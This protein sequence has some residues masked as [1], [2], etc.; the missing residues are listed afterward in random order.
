VFR[1]LGIIG[2]LTAVATTG[3]VLEKRILEVRRLR[4]RQHFRSEVLRDRRAELQL[5]TQ[6]FSGAKELAAP[7]HSGLMQP[8]NDAGQP[9][10]PL[11]PLPEL[12]LPVPRSEA[13]R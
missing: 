1:F 9:G 8:R 10:I 11:V 5:I 4:S 7:I 6:Q 2:L 13:A 3:I 12:R